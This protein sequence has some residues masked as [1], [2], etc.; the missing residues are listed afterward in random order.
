MADY[1]FRLVTVDSETVT[2][3]QQRHLLHDQAALDWMSQEM[4]GSGQELRAYR[5]G[6]GN[7]FAVRGFAETPRVVSR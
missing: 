3:T 2:D 4:I 7:P 1:T 6:E 5:A